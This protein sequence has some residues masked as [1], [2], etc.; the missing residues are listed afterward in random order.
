MFTREKTRPVKVK[1]LTI[2]SNNQVIIQ[3]MTN[4]ST[5]NTQ[6]TINQIKVLEK[7]GCQIVRVAVLDEADALAISEIKKHISIPLV[8]DIHFDYRLALLAIESGVDKIRINPGNIADEEKIFAVVEACKSKGIPI[9]IGI[10]SGSLEKHI[11]KKYHHPTP[12]AMVESATYHIGL[13]EKYGFYDII[14]SLKSSSVI[15]TIKANELA[16]NTFDYPL[17]LGITEAGSTFG[18]TISSSIGLGVMLNQGIGSTIRVS[19]TADPVEEIRVAKEILSNF[20]LFKKP[21]LIS[22][23]TCGRIQY[24]MFPIVNEIESFL[25]FIDKDITVAIM[26]CIVNGPG[27]AKEANIAIAGGKNEVLVF[28]DGIKQFKVKQEDIVETLKKLILDY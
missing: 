20:G 1:N 28:V 8:A 17:H 12:E 18:G 21:K 10:N 24:D 13:L 14:V 23:P 15:D 19:L 9:R 16:A 25:E 4:T 5:K 7:A 27:E 11:L 2:G 26:G 3:S 6:A 22:C